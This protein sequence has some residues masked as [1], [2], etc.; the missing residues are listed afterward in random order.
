M[1]SSKRGGGT[2]H[3]HDDMVLS[4]REPKLMTAI[5][6]Q[7]RNFLSLFYFEAFCQ[8][9]VRGNIGQGHRGRFCK[10]QRLGFISS[11]SLVNKL[12]F[13]IRAL[14][15]RTARVKYLVSYFEEGTLGTSVF[16]HARSIVAKDL[17]GSRNVVV[18][19]C[20]CR[21]DFLANTKIREADQDSCRKF[22]S[23]LWCPRDLLTQL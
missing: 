11:T 9:L 18:V 19:V 4:R 5:N 16:H 8:C 6:D 1:K 3:Q 2:Q 15:Y 14:P 23:G 17:E 22:L 7:Q 20:V 10:V 12:I 13:C 21:R